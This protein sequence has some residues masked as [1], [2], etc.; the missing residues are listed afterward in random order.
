MA[1]ECKYA[2][3]IGLQI[4]EPSNFEGIV[5]EAE[6]NGKTFRV[7]NKSYSTE[8]RFPSPVH[9][10]R[11]VSRTTQLGG[12]IKYK[13]VQEDYF[14]SKCISCIREINKDFWTHIIS[15]CRDGRLEPINPLFKWP[16]SFVFKEN[17]DELK[18]G[19]LLWFYDFNNFYPSI[20]VRLG[21]VSKEVIDKYTNYID[22][23]TNLKR[24]R[25]IALSRIRSI[26]KVDYFID[27]K[28]SH[29]IESDSS[30]VE[31]AYT[32]IIMWGRNLINQTCFKYSYRVIGRDI[33]NI[34]LPYNKS[35]FIPGRYLTEQGMDY[36]KYL[37]RKISNNQF[38][39]IYDNRI[40]TVRNYINLADNGKEKG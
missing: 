19:D 25:N 4:R 16:Q 37:C 24:S 40:K 5:S 9:V 32:N 6:T 35:T 30:Y 23:T 15:L 29:S 21:Y 36:K 7:V 20:A 14:D 3:D 12:Y 8:M 13:I 26:I 33:D 1:F 2:G 18:I 11:S 28:Y 17:W 39:I 27:G 22:E 38:K 10:P 31:N 34:L